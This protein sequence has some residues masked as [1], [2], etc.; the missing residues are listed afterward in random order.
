MDTPL[1]GKIENLVQG[2]FK[3]W[4]EG[5]LTILHLYGSHQWL[6]CELLRS[7]TPSLNSQKAHLPPRAPL[8]LIPVSFPLLGKV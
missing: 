5:K 3:L 7:S 8:R 2:E 4:I 1:C 6:I